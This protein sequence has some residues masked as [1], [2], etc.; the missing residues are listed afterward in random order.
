MYVIDATTYNKEGEAV[1][2][3]CLDRST[4]V[5]YS[6]EKLYPREYGMIYGGPGFLGV[7]GFNSLIPS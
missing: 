4:K 5:Q 1:M 3:F 7:A 6:K 2:T